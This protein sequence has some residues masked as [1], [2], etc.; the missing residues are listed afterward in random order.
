M[1]FQDIDASASPEVQINEN[2]E[3][4]D[5]AAVYSKRQE[6]TTGLTWGYR[7]GRWGGFAVSAGTL[8]LTN[9]ATNYVVVLRSNGVISVSTTSTNWDN[10]LSYA[11][12]YKLTVAGGVVTAVEDHRA[13]PNGIFGA[14]AGAA[15]ELR[16]LTFT[17]DTDSTADSDPGAGLFK[18]NNATQA[19]ATA[20][21]FDDQTADGVSL[22]TLWGS[23]GESGMISLQQGDDSSRWQEWK[24][25]AIPVDGPGYRKFTVTLQA[26]SASAIQDDKLVLVDFETSVPGA[27]VGPASATDGAAAL[28]DGTTGKL[29]KTSKVTITVPATGATITIADGKTLTASNTL[30]ITATDGSTL[31]VGSGAA[32]SALG[33]LTP[34]ADRLAYFTGASTANLI[35]FTAVARQ[36]LGQATQALMRTTGLAISSV[37]DTLITQTTQAA[38]RSTGL[39]LDTLTQPLMNYGGLNFNGTTTY[40][41][42]NGLT[43]IADGKKGSLFFV[44]RFAN[45]AGTAEILVDNT[46]AQLRV[47]RSTTGNIQVL[48]ENAAGTQI[49]SQ[50]TSGVPCAAAGTY[51]IMISWDLATPG[52]FKI[53][54]NDVS[55]AV[56][57]TTF[58]DDTIDYT[59]TE[60]A[61]GA[62]TT[63]AASFLNGDLYI[64]WFDP[65]TAQDFSTASVRR[66]F[67]DANN[68][69]Q[70]LGRNGEL[71]TGSTPILF[72]AYD[73]AAQWPINRGSAQSTTFTQN[74]TIAAAS[75]TLQG[76]WC[77]LA[78]HGT[79]K[80]VTADYTVL[81]TDET[82]INDRAATNTLTLPDP[83]TCKNR[84]LNVLTI[85][86]QAVNSASSN[87]IPITGGAAGTAI[88]GASDGAWCEMQSTGA[89]W[90]IIKS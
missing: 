9:T 15:A 69:P 32:L 50:Q 7:G 33:A 57:S 67:T 52:S 41:D 19:S 37:A 17:S 48:A 54:V 42:T 34:A 24:W 11:R 39:G 23:L 85:Q 90:Q 72:L 81:A 61:I 6:V 28:F 40:L 12:V 86:A 29:I 68:V 22:T 21:Y 58:T 79:I 31:A 36:L 44:V 43:G 45:A 27:V 14:I 25:T 59:V 2:F 3:S 80:T 70:Y 77:P 49:L 63:G 75:T 71:P 64:L 56:T 46:G 35:T 82:I 84:K 89:A 76:Q 38:M 74:G 47:L 88:L 16:G 30:T 55:A 78:S 83:T 1:N 73:S 4:A 26:A 10:V 5:F 60:Y 53:Y 62:N 13:G 87:V 66:K 65:T 51:E 18:W 8:T 20:L